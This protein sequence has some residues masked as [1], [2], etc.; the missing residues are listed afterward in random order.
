MFH[1]DSSK[2]VRTKRSGSLS[3]GGEEPEDAKEEFGYLRGILNHSGKHGIRNTTDLHAGKKQGFFRRL[4]HSSSHPIDLFSST[5]AQPTAHKTSEKSP[6]SPKS[7]QSPQ[8]PEGS[9]SEPHSTN[10]THNNAPA[11]SLQFPV[12]DTLC[13]FIEEHGADETGLF[14]VRGKQEQST[15]LTTAFK[16]WR[17][18]EP[19]PH[20]EEDASVHDVA[21]ALKSYLR[22][23]QQPTIACSF[24]QSFIDVLDIED[25]TKQLD[26]L[27]E[28]ISKLPDNNRVVL[29]RVVQML[30]VIEKQS[31]HNMTSASDLAV[32]FGPA[33]MRPDDITMDILFQTKFQCLIV[34]MF[35]SYSTYLFGD[36]SNT[37]GVVSPTLTN[38]NAKKKR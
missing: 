19:L 32:V 33:L 12:V 35:I 20:I 31:L 27:K 29:R 2:S 24:Y 15:E 23:Q 6:R 21:T 30:S 17:E 14:R 25:E 10:K 18:G 1:R 22:E 7:H 38:F 16:E 3:T 36:E 8:A 13:T 34:E 26:E 28:Q 37:K 5:S 4:S 9:S 11:E